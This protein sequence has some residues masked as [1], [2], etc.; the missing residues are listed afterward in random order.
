[1]AWFLLHVDDVRSDMS[2]YHRVDHIETLPASRL[3]RLMVRLPVYGGAVAF[4]IRQEPT[5]P[6]QSAPEPAPAL[7]AN[8]LQAMNSSA[9]Y[10]PMAGQTV[11]LF[12]VTTVPG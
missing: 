3:V 10:G 12:E 4:T 6:A 7:T 2:R 5:E 8:Q 1:M 9:L 11:G